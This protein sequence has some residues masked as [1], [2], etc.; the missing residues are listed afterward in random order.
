MM[1]VF[2]LA[3]L[4]LSSGCLCDSGN[5]EQPDPRQCDSILSQKSKDI[6]IK[7]I[8][9]ALGNATLCETVA[10]Q[11]IRLWCYATALRDESYCNRMTKKYGT[12]T[13]DRDGCYTSVAGITKKRNICNKVENPDEI[14]ECIKQ[15]D[16]VPEP[17]RREQ[18][19]ASVNSRCGNLTG[20]MKPG[21]R[22][23]HYDCIENL[24]VEEKSILVCDAT[25]TL[26]RSLPPSMLFNQCIQ[27]YADENN[28]TS[29]CEKASMPKDKGFCMALALD[30]WRECQKITCDFSCMIEGIETQKDLCTLWYA[31]EIK[32]ATI[33]PQVMREDYR[34]ICEDMILEFQAF[35]TR[36]NT[37]CAKIKDK[38]RR[39][40]CE[41]NLK[42]FT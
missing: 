34:G 42:Q 31:T 25:N 17:E 12:P 37:L 4:V 18:L 23:V 21:E 10:D 7:G 27:N 11:D 41:D 15:A 1:C 29:V 35:D 39:S 33:C 13:P 16:Y 28:D 26:N 6:C 5:D 14:A 3:A 22:D 19:L 32:D 9:A 24:A 2:L 38:Q 20:E 40:H 30:D 36:N 8:S